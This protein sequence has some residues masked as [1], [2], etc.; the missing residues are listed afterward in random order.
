MYPTRELP[1]GRVLSVLPMTF[2]KGRLC[3]Q[4][5]VFS[6]CY[7]DVWCYPSVPAAIAAMEAWDGEGEPTGWHRHPATGRRRPEGD[8]A[9]EYVHP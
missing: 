2:G 6:L 7:E 1:D 5:H 9:K 3:V 4:A 8:P